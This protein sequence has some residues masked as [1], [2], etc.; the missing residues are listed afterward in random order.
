MVTKQVGKQAGRWVVP[1]P[2]LPR[3]FGLMNITFGILLLLTAVGYGLMYAYAPAF[4]EFMSRP[5]KQIEEKAKADRAAKIAALK[6]EEAAAKTEA[7][8]Q[9]LADERAALEAK[10]VPDM[11]AFN[12]LQDLN[13]YTEP[14]LA[15]FYILDISTAV[16]LNVLMIVTGGGLMGLKEWA[17]RLAIRVAQLKILR[18]L[19][20]VVGAMAVIMPMTME[21][22]QPAI[23]AMDAQMNAAGA[24]GMPF[25]LASIMRWMFIF[26]VV[27]MIFAAIVACVY[28]AIMWWNLTRPAARAACL[29][30][31]PKPELPEPSAKWETTV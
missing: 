2:Q 3:S 13:A 26:G 21:K 11:S 27:F 10:V 7:E 9:T 23:N 19:A 24:G 29:K 28:P 8:K 17:R 6:A 20:M 12:D 30:L 18:W 25:P 16:V 1:N 22:M 4:Q 14:R 5:M 15:I 31:E